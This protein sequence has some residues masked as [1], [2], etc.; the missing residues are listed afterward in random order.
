M[1]ISP[2]VLLNSDG[3]L[4]IPQPAARIDLHLQ[5]VLIKCWLSSKTARQ[6]PI[7]ILVSTAVYMNRKSSVRLLVCVYRLY[8]LPAEDTHIRGLSEGGL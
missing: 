7:V 8:P 6:K 2:A 4:L 5:I 1:K 3:G